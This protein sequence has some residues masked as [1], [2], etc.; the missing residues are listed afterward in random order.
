MPDAAAQP[1]DYRPRLR[2]SASQVQTFVN[3]QRAWAWKYVAGVEEPSSPAAERGKAGHAQLETYL[4]GGEIDFTEEIGYVAA[5]GLHHLP[6]PGTDGL[7]VEQEFHFEGPSGHTYLGY[8]DAWVPGTIYDHK[9]TSDLRWQ[10]TPEQLEGDVQA[11]LYATDYFR[12]HPDDLI[13]EMRWVYYQ[14]KNAKKSA[15]TAVRVDQ[16]STWKRFQEIESIAEQ[17]SAASTL[18]PLDLPPSINHCSAYGGCPH[19]GRCNLSPFDKMRSHVEQNKLVA[20]LKNRNNGAGAAPSAGSVPSAAFGPG[21]A[22]AGVLPGVAGVAAPA[23]APTANKLLSRMRAGGAP[24]ATSPAP[25][26]INPPE[27][28]PPPAAPPAAAQ[29]AAAPLPLTTEAAG[30][31]FAASLQQGAAE[32]PRGRGRPQKAVVPA[33]GVTEKIKTLYIN[34]GPVGVAV[35]DAGQL[36]VL[37]KKKIEEATGLADYRFAAFGQGPGML[38]VAVVA[39]LDALEGV[40][41]AVRLDTTTPE[42]QVVA[43]ELMARAGLVVR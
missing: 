42:G 39:A 17:M 13:V 14:M 2:L 26:A 43:V 6:K 5:A 22:H 8:K 10:K 25:A 35:V 1:V 3:C 38:A 30:A 4:L 9:F 37:A 11:T 28:Q 7:R 31:E 12:E 20:N 36:I 40:V 24:A 34:C 41:P 15:V 32:A 19:Q 18:G 23:A 29:P 33:T 16:A 21:G 27:Y